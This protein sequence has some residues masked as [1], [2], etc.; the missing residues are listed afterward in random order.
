[1]SAHTEST[2]LNEFQ[3][4]HT[5]AAVGELPPRACF[6]LTGADR[7]KFLHN[8][9]TNDIKSLKPGQ[10]CE[11]LMTSVQG[12]V[13]AHL[14]VQAAQDS[15]WIEADAT[16]REIIARHLNKYLITEDV[17]IHD[18]SDDFRLL[19]ACGPSMRK[20]L[21]EGGLTVSEDP[22]S[23]NHSRG[24][25]REIP[26]VW[27]Q[28]RWT[29]PPNWTLR[30]AAEDADGLLTSLTTA[31]VTFLSAE[32]IDALRIEAGFPRDGIDFNDSNL[33][34]ELARTNLCISFRK[35]CYLGQEPIARIDSMG[36]VNQELRKVTLTGDSPSPPGTGLIDPATEK[37]AGTLTSV[38]CFPIDGR[39]SAIAMLRRP[40]LAGGTDLKTPHGTAKVAG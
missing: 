1:M 6:E 12:K 7:H 33:A 23:L 2:S 28:T 24:I 13:L 38:S 30:A 27:Q 19:L 31:G 17:Q 32:A 8:F 36:H 40:F 14:T 9:C 21:L 11:A 18:R 34:Q 29:P 15:L 4:A 37:E 3:T 26:V 22:P 39:W 25:F 10:G 5:G 16:R 20:A 35:G